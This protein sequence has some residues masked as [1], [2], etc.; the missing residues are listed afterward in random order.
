MVIYRE[1]THPD[2][3]FD[4]ER[5]VQVSKDDEPYAYIRKSAHNSDLE[6]QRE[7]DL[8]N[9]EDIDEKN[10]FMQIWNKYI[11][12]NNVMGVDVLHEE[13]IEQETRDLSIE[14]DT[15]WRKDENGKFCEYYYRNLYRIFGKINGK[16][17]VISHP[18]SIQ[19]SKIGDEVIKDKKLKKILWDKISPLVIQRWKDRREASARKIKRKKRKAINDIIATDKFQKRLTE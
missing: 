6:A 16:D 10:I 19:D 4:K 3:I 5:H 1:N 18:R 8:R 2:Q 7:A 11:Y 17:V 9:D 15:F 12:S 14:K 13:A